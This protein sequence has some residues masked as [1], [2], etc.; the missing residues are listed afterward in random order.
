MAP[1][2]LA[3]ATLCQGGCWHSATGATVAG[4]T[5]AWG[6]GVGVVMVERG[7]RLSV[8][9]ATYTY[10]LTRTQSTAHILQSTH[11]PK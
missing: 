3:G 11:S 4:F 7:S 10:V 5:S 1:H 2:V 6:G 9:T 8:A